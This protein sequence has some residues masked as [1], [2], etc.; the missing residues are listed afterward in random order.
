[1]AKDQAEAMLERLR[2]G[3]D[4]SE[5]AR[6]V[7]QDPVTA[8]KGGDLGLIT[9][10]ERPTI[11]DAVFGTPAGEFA[12]VTETPFGYEVIQVTE[13][14]P[15]GV[16]PLEEVQDGIRRLL[17]QRGAQERVRSETERIRNEVASPEDLQAVASSEGLEVR[18]RIV[19]RDERLGDLGP[20]P[21]F[22][23]AVFSMAPGTV[24]SPLG[25]AR[26]MAVVVVDEIHPPGLASFDEVKDRA[27]TDLLNDRSRS[28]AIESARR[29]LARRKNLEAVAKSLDAE[30]KKSGDLA[31][32]SVILPGSGGPSPELQE[33]LFRPEAAEGDKGVVPVES[34][35]LVYSITKRTGFDAASFEAQ[36]EGLRVELMGERR[37]ALVGSILD[38][39]RVEYEVEINHEVMTRLRG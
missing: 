31:P 20:S 28:A 7:S 8:P 4:F 19:T 9:R 2:G 30:V 37:E 34:G 18:E 1:V 27:K 23:D 22:M 16:L 6:A 32:T 29:A 38:K 39:L 36:K 10:G 35:A 21:E 13:A 3:A 26:G 11:E 24:S 33:A 15:A 12:P 25:V 17:E 5:L 14:R